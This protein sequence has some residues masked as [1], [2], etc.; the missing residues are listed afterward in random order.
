M[1]Q[2]AYNI[3]S[4]LVTDETR[5]TELECRDYVHYAAFYLLP[6]RPIEVYTENEHRNF[7]GSSDF[8]VAARLRNDQGREENYAYIW[9]LKAPQSFLFESDDNKNRFRPTLDFVKAENQLLHYY[10]EAEGNN[11][12]RERYKVMNTK[13]IKI[14]GLIIGRSDR[15][16][17][18]LGSSPL[19]EQNVAKA[20]SVR[21]NYLYAT[22]KIRILTWDAI[23]KAVQP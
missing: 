9:E 19:D 14:G 17:K 18:G 15:L 10:S 22:Y 23:L 11:N 20:L 6:T 2:D 5:R 7:F 16:A 1:D 13:N 21:E 4:A 3:F 12:F 8:I